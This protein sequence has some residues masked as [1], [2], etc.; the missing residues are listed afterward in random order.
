MAVGKMPR[1]TKTTKAKRRAPAKR[2][3]VPV[4]H[5]QPNPP[6]AHHVNSICSLNDPFCDHAIGAK[7]FDSTAS[8]SLA[9]KVQ[10]YYYITTNASGSAANL[11][12]PNY[13][14][15]WPQVPSTITGTNCDYASPATPN[16]PIGG[17]IG[18]YRIVSFGLRLKCI[19]APLYAS[20]IV[21][22]RYLSS[23]SG[24]SYASVDGTTNRFDTQLN[25]PLQDCKDVVLLG[26][27]CN[28]TSTFYTAPT[29]TLASGA[30]PQTWVGNGW[31]TIH[32][33]VSGAPVSSNVLAVEFMVHYESVP[34]D[35]NAIGALMTPAKV[36]NPL[37]TEA[38]Q[39]ISSTAK[40]IFTAGIG[41]ASNYVK[42]AAIAAIAMRLGGPGAAR[43]AIMVD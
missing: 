37:I 30:F 41:A 24:A 10:Q 35:S 29:T 14:N 28:A 4:N 23:Q 32:I 42:K 38:S 7:Y 40:S 19:A 9:H 33:F 36:A 21:N 18:Q 27:R 12:L 31:D 5:N 17:E 13:I 11:I 2:A 20:G 25:I 6:P 1:K 43:A 22:I 3:V 16:Q 15:L 34:D 26:R 39:A 8:R